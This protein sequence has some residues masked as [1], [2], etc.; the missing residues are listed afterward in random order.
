MPDG[1]FLSKSIAWNEQL[2]S[3]SFEA[4]HLFGRMIPFLDREGRAIGNPKGI[5]GMC[6]SL[7]D[8]MTPEVI[9]RSLGELADKGL[10]VWYRVKGSLFAYFPGFVNHQKGARLK[11]EAASRFPSHKTSGVELVRP[12]SH[13]DSDEGGSNSATSPPK[14]RIREVKRSKAKRSQVKRSKEAPNAHASA[15]AVPDK[16]HANGNGKPKRTTWLTPF[17]DAWQEMYGGKM[18][19]EPATRPLKA[20]C[21]SLGAEETLRRFEIYVSQTPAQFASPARFASTLNEWE[22]PKVGGGK[23]NTAG[24]AVDDEAMTRA[25]E[26]YDL[27]TE[28]SLLKFEGNKAEYGA[29]KQRAA[30]DR[31]AG[32]GFDADLKATRL[33]EG[34]T[35][36]PPQQ[37]IKEIARRLVLA[38]NG[39]CVAP[40]VKAS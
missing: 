6:V 11:R 25:R 29:A 37:A 21:E 17:A 4:D 19:I 9:E 22:A 38:R 23:I 20:A 5:K 1:R 26:L 14:V 40:A 28:F 35:G 3:V 33:W 36:V 7:R 13:H 12:T 8:E 27:G 34:L 18:S 32:D 24:V 39:N 16:Q 15:V 10:I 30:L 31:R 2:G